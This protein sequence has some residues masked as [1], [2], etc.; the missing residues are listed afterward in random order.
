MARFRAWAQEQKLP[1]SDQDWEGNREAIQEQL[2]IEMQ[3]VAFGVE[4]GF[5][6]QCEKDPAILKALELM[7]EA[8][9]LLRKKQLLHRAAP[10]AAA[11]LR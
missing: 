5:K 10:T 1:I 8:E 6:L 3:N 9:A 11:A 4:A 2:S 7:P